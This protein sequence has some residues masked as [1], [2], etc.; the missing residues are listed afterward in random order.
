[1]TE[2]HEMELEHSDEILEEELPIDASKLDWPKRFWDIEA[3]NDLFLWG[4]K[5]DNNKYE[6]HYLASE[7][8]YRHAVLEACRIKRLQNGGNKIAVYNLAKDASRLRYHMRQVRPQVAKNAVLM[9][10]LGSEPVDTKPKQAWYLSFNGLGYDLPMMDYVL[11]AITNNRLQTTPQTIRDYSNE[12]ISSRDTRNIRS[13]TK[14]HELHGNQI[15]IAK[16]EEK[17]WNEGVLVKGLKTIVG[18]MGGNIVETESNITGV[19]TDP[20]ADVLYHFNDLDISKWVF[21]ITKLSKT[22]EIRTTLSEMYES[23]RAY[24]ITQNGTSAK[25]VEFIVSPHAH[26]QDNPVVDFMYPAEHV[27][28]RHGIERFDVLEYFRTWYIQ[29]VYAQVSKHNKRMALV[30]LAKFTSIYNSFA[31]VRGKNMNTLDSHYAQYGIP[32]IAFHEMKAQMENAFATQLMLID[33]YGRE[34]GTYVKFSLGG[35]HGADYYLEQLEQDRAKIREL[36]VDYKKLSEVPRHRVSPQLFALLRKQS[37]SQYMDYPVAVSHEIPEFFKKTVEVDDIIAPEDF[38]P[39]SVEPPSDTKKKKLGILSETLLERYRYTSISKVVHQDFAGY[40]P[41]LIINLGIFYDGNGLD[42]Y[43]EVYKLR[44]GI[45]AKLKTLKYG[46]PE[47]QKADLMQE[48]YKLVLNSASGI[49]DGKGFVDTNLRAN[50]KGVAMRIIG[51]LFTYILAQALA[52]EGASVPSSNTDGIYVGNIETDLNQQIIDRELSKL[53]V[54]IDPEECLLISKDT[55]NRVEVHDGSVSAKGGDLTASN[56]ATIDKSLDHVALADVVLA[57][58]LQAHEHIEGGMDA[59]KD[60][61]LMKQL[62]LEYMQTED[63]HRFLWMASW[64]M[65]STKGSF[66]IDQ[67]GNIYEGT[68]RVWMTKTG[69]ALEKIAVNKS[70]VSTK[71]VQ[72]AQQLVASGRGNTPLGDEL[73]VSQLLQQGLGHLIDKAITARELVNIVIDANNKGIELKDL[74][75]VPIVKRGK[76]TKYP[77]GA[78]MTLHNESIWDMTDEEADAILAQLDIDQYVTAISNAATNWHNVLQPS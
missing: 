24:G 50:N 21:E 77:D 10:Y 61:A 22:F 65:R 8:K 42:P 4:V 75:S 28:K 16:L 27:A 45:K 3:W 12:L 66:R 59:P 52:L 20:V 69:K 15:D 47:Y 68:I 9:K 54:Q 51:Q 11:K 39:F 70:K 46:S 7:D 48:G 64:V 56:G 49:L 53:L 5:L 36:R 67:D 55:N 19:M 40:Y 74:E 6:I 23:L 34:S 62:L 1:M 18:M 38:S 2:V 72:Q 30:Q 37:R 17:L 78:L 26:I 43:E 25:H 44:L 71:L 32:G 63:K 58:Y 57:K 29:N 76:I 14:N 60:E 31:H 73:T 33:K 13:N 41:M 35:I